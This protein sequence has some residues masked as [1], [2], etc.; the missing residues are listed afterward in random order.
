M[1]LI[2]QKSV[3][4]RQILLI[5]S[6]CYV[7]TGLKNI[8]KF[9]LILTYLFEPRTILPRTTEISLEQEQDRI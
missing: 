3:S 8:L 5:L 6:K 9:T 2:P 7:V 4:Q 1:Y